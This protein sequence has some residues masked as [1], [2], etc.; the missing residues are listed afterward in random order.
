MTNTAE[1]IV[2]ELQN[3]P[4][5]A[6]ELSQSMTEISYA[7][8]R[9]ILCRLFDA[10]TV[11]KLKRGVYQLAS[12]DRRNCSEVVHN[13]MMT[14]GQSPKFTKVLVQASAKQRSAGFRSVPVCHLRDAV[15]EAWE[16]YYAMND[17]FDYRAWM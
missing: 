16:D 3:G 17:P 7:N 5:S 13:S 11:T 4:A 10:G 2:T 12:S 1:K 15:H 6:R 9:Q 8:I 14:E